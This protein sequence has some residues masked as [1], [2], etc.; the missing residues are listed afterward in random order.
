MS[1]DILEPLLGSIFQAHDQCPIFSSIV[2][3]NAQTLT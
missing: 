2:G 3:C 1:T